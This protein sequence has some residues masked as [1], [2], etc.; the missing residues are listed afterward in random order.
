MQPIQLLMLMI[1]RSDGRN[2][3]GNW[4]HCCIQVKFP[5]GTLVEYD[6]QVPHLKLSEVVQVVQNL[7][8]ISSS[9]QLNSLRQHLDENLA[10]LSATIFAVRLLKSS[11]SEESGE[12]PSSASVTSQTTDSDVASMD[13]GG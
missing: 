2:R 5:S 3:L 13:S 9:L 8:L 4:Y 1:Q 7:S 10:P 6:L 11:S 12:A